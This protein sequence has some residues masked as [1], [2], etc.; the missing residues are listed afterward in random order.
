MVSSKSLGDFTIGGPGWHITAHLVAVVALVVACLAISGHITFRDDSIAG[1]KLKDHAANFEDVTLTSMTTAAGQEKWY[2]ASV[3]PLAAATHDD[4]DS[5][6][7]LATGLPVGAVVVDSFM[8]VVTASTLD[9]GALI[10]ET[11]TAAECAVGGVPADPLS[12]GGTLANST[13]LAYDSGPAT[14]RTEFAFT[15]ADNSICV[16]AAAAAAGNNGKVNFGVLIRA[17]PGA[18]L[19][20]GVAL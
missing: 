2:F 6:A 4:D 18:A 13:L 20:P 11:G 19:L 16:S 15:A 7:L 12:G 14:G 1:S 5:I 10:F 3:G 8:Q 9:L 17:P